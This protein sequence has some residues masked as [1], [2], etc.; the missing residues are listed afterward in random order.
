MPGMPS[1]LP[2][3]IRSRMEHRKCYSTKRDSGKSETHSAI[4]RGSNRNHLRRLVEN[5]YA[6]EINSKTHSQVLEGI[7]GNAD[8]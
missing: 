1:D 4:L 7:L 5:E 6:L 3:H 8:R 2:K